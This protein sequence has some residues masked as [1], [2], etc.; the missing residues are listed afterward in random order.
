MDEVMDKADMAERIVE[1][2][3]AKINL[4]LHV[5]A[6]RSD[7]Y[8]PLSSLVVFADA[9]DGVTARPADDFSL[10]LSG[11]FAAGLSAGD[12]NLVLRA[13]RHAHSQLGGPKLAFHLIKNLPSSSG[14]GGGSADGAAAMRLVAR[15]AGKPAS[16]IYN[17]A[18]IGADIPVCLGSRTAMMRGIGESIEPVTGCGRLYGILVNPGVAV[19]TGA[20]FKSFDAGP[21]GDLTQST[22]RDVITAARA[23]RNDLQP[24]ACELAPDILTVLAQLEAQDGVRLSRMTGSGASCYAITDSLNSA[25]NIAEHLCAQ[26]PHWWVWY[27]GFGDPL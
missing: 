21:P 18:S 5:G 6:A 25:R 2:A 24:A 12:D 27:G 7:G 9:A 23:G 26:N 14:M 22:R 3:R 10:T 13:A 4:T 11:P 1:L 20:I 16:S 19:S 17:A 8:H 15:F